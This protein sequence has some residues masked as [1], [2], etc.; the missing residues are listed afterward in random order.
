M[1]LDRLAGGTSG[2]STPHP[3]G[4]PY[5]P[6]PR[7]TPSALSP[8]VTSQRPGHSTRSS[9]LSI[10]SNDSFTSLLS[11]SRRLNIS[12]LRHS[13][14]PAVTCSPT[15]ML[16]RWLSGKEYSS[17]GSEEQTALILEA[18]LEFN[19]DFRGFA[20]TELVSFVQ[21][22]DPADLQ[23]EQV[24]HE[25]SLPPSDAPLPDCVRRR[26]E[27]GK[28]DE[29]NVE[30]LHRSVLACD[31]ILNSVD[32]N[33][34]SF[35]NELAAVSADIET[36]QSRSTALNRRLENRIEMEKLLG[37]IVEELSVSP[38]L[39]F[40]ILDGHMDESWLMA[41]AAVERKTIAYHKKRSLS[42]SRRNPSS[43]QLEPLLEKLTIRAAE[44]IRD[45]LV[46]QIKALRSPHIN[47]Q[48][49]QQQSFLRFKDM[50][51]FLQK[52]HSSLAQ[53]IS[54][55]YMNTM[56][57]YYHNQF[58]RHDTLGHE[59]T[60][61]M[62]AVISSSRA[63]GP[64]FDAF[65]L[66][67]RMDLLKAKNMTALPSYLAEEERT[68]HFI[69]APF[70]NFNLALMDNASAEYTF[71]ASFFS[72]AISLSQVSKNFNYIFEP[73]FELGR[74]LSRSLVGETFDSLGIL[75]CIR[76]NQLFAFELQRRKVPALDGYINA[77]N[78]LL[79]P[80]L[81]LVMDRHCE[82]M[83][84]LTHSLPTKPTRSTEDTSK[85]TTAPH[86]VT[87]R[88][89]RLLHGFL[90]LSADAGDNEPLVASLHRLRSEVETFLIRQS[91]S[92]GA[93][94][95]RSNRFLYNNFSLILTIMGDAD[96]MLA[97]DHRMHFEQL[98]AAHQE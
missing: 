59:D 23:H 90:R 92:F 10:V 68:T 40:K 93:D 45:F 66:G 94:E 62:A 16:G 9:S 22:T 5:S 1:W 21:N 56:R 11:S 81:Q 34:S 29:S 70:R 50:Y 46:V 51:S 57:W 44:R 74:V 39:I 43:E 27:R 55:A 33:L 30:D 8:Y 26:F 19:A 31:D 71:L 47:A 89:G 28:G 32:N 37:P 35:R 63:A 60:T 13:S 82:S 3:V 36:L 14:T 48:I 41:L 52:R 78:M 54:L 75:M 76:L 87:Q 80:R 17:D 96:G 7:R 58:S 67:H 42:R 49:I 79:W 95:R 83:R 91:Q 18:D 77:T 20:L 38:D 86:V 65:N 25:I 85:I 15:G 12:G 73:A 72:P 4:R 64:P 97:A 2:S 6:L 88:F 53:E 24:V 69:E 84:Q 98:K 61:R